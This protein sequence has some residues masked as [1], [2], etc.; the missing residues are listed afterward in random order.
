M[1]NQWG[2]YLPESVFTLMFYW[3]RLYCFCLG[4]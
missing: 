4:S 1:P 2:F 3:D